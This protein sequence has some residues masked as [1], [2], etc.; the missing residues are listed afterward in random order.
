MMK[1]P[2][3]RM[4]ILH[5]VGMDEDNPEYIN[6]KQKQQTKFKARLEALF[7]KYGNMHE[8]MSDEIDMKS[9]SVIVDRGHLRRLKRQV[10]RKETLLLDTL[11]LEAGGEL[12]EVSEEEGEREDSEDELAPTQPTKSNSG[13]TRRESEQQ[14]ESSGQLET[15]D[16]STTIQQP[17]NPA[18]PTAQFTLPQVHNT[19]SPTASLM[20]LA[21]FPQTP[22]GQQAQ[23]AFYTALTQSINQTV[24]QAVLQAVVPLL[25]GLLPPNAQ[26]PFAKALPAPTTPVITS[27]RVAPATDPKWFF[28]PLSAEVR[29]DPVAQSS[30]LAT[31]TTAPV[32]EELVNRQGDTT[33]RQADEKQ[34]ESVCAELP[35]RP[36]STRPSTGANLNW[37]IRPR[38]SSPRVEIPRRRV[39]PAEKYHFTEADDVYISQQRRIH[40][41]TWAAIKDSKPK[42]KKWPLSAFY[43]HWNQLQ[44]KNLHLKESL[45]IRSGR[46]VQANNHGSIGCVPELSARSHHLPTPSSLEQEDG[47]MEVIETRED[48]TKDNGLSSSAHFDDEERELLSLAGADEV[49]E[50]LPLL[51][52]EE[53]LDLSPDK[54]IP[55]IEMRDH[56]D[57]DT[58]QQSLLEEL[59]MRG[60]TVTP[61]RPAP[62]HVKTEPVPSPSS[63]TQKRKRLSLNVKVVPDS[64]AEDED[65]VG[66]DIPFVCTICY[67]PFKNAKSLTRHQ[68]NPRNMHN[69]ALRKSTSLDLVGGADELQDDVASTAPHI[70]RET[71]TP[72]RNVFSAFQTPKAASRHLGLDS[73]STSKVDRKTYLKQVKQSWTRGATSVKSVAK[74]KSMGSLVSRKRVW[75]GDEASEDE[76]AM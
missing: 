29:K 69:A 75:T 57:E 58:L 38:R 53:L 1:P 20:Q 3:K 33:V 54:V 66:P 21:Q 9:N 11:A 45:A 4:R 56:I 13:R 51:H 34:P 39:V 12:E 15:S 23:A 61:A 25:T 35:E 27:D 6:A 30:L 32:V 74:R 24:N 55:S 22:A 42:W 10:G 47:P 73:K 70:K 76:L 5:S 65:Q 72:P 16:N 48:K 37:P 43:N 68:D 19:P 59:S 14:T 31:H 52:D 8:S 17:N 62:V 50:Q 28:P 67:K 7:E 71:S 46:G 18:I 2:A 40:Y 63:S 64:D 41:T 44:H 36:P 26:L 49:E 60:S